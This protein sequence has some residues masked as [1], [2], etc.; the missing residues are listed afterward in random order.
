MV[1]L[2]FCCVI[3]R[4]NRLVTIYWWIQED[5]PAQLAAVQEAHLTTEQT[6]SATREELTSM[7]IELEKEINKSHE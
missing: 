1:L 4:D 7:K 3:S 5:D 2:I 6:L